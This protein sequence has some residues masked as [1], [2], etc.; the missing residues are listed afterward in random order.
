MCFLSELGNLA[1]QMELRL[2]LVCNTG[3]YDS[4]ESMQMMEGIVDIYL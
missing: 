1:V 2:P 3:A 4:M